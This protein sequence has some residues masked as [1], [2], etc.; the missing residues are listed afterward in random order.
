MCCGTTLITLICFAYPIPCHHLWL[1]PPIILSQH[2][3]DLLYIFFCL[4]FA[5]HSEDVVRMFVDFVPNAGVDGQDL[6]PIIP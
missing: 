6:C 4:Y 2:L 3:Q 5:H 1:L